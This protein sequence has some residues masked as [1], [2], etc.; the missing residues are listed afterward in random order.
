VFFAGSIAVLLSAC[1][2]NSQSLAQEQRANA[3]EQSAASDQM[4]QTINRLQIAKAR[5]DG[6]INNPNI[7][8]VRREDF[9]VQAAKAD[10]AIKELQHGYP[11]PHDEIED[12]LWEVPS[13]RISPEYRA[14]LIQQLLQAKQLDEKRE[15]EILIYWKDDQ[16]IER[17]K[18]SVQAEYA[19]KVAKD[20]QLGESVHWAEIEEALYV[21]PDA[22]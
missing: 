19:A 1:A 12:A 7:T 11:V 5:D 10:R 16:P 15:Q 9:T 22:L 2:P 3:I 4:T 6:N 18:F 20:L 13:Q 21:P 17:S 14:Q 8:A